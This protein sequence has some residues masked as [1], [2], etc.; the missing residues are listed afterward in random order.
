MNPEGSPCAHK[1]CK[2]RVAE[3]GEKPVM[4]DGKAYCTQRCADGRGCDHEGCN[5]GAFPAPE[6]E[7]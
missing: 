6:P 2:C 5:C 3:G 1:G 7:I 4:W